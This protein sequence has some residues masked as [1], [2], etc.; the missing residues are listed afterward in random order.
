MVVAIPSHWATAG[1][2]IPSVCAKH[3]RPEVR[4]SRISLETATPD[5]QYLLL[6]IGILAFFLVRSLTAK[7]LAV[8]AWPFCD[9]CLRERLRLKWIAAGTFIVGLVLFV[10]AV[11]GLL[12]PAAAVLMA[13]LM[14]V[15]GLAFV[16]GDWAWRRMS[17]AKL[18][19][20]AGWITVAKPH[21]AFEE[22]F[23]PYQPAAVE[24]WNSTGGARASKNGSA[25]PWIL[26]LIIGP[27]CVAAGLINMLIGPTC[28]DE[29]MRPGDICE[30]TSSRG[31]TRESTYDS[32]RQIGTIVTGL[33]VLTLM[34]GIAGIV[35]TRRRKRA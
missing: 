20:D 6:L 33:G 3:G 21:A 30:E 28:G 11:R 13:V 14:V 18:S 15:G 27:I 1:Y 12:P 8:T 2:G 22:Q 26:A 25:A 34:G 9:T 7:T 24:L 17:R 29:R 19:E 16:R 31:S 35:I 4:R 5:W 32:E 10:A 23:A